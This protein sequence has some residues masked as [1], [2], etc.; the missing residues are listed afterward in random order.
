M[1]VNVKLY[2][3]YLLISLIYATAYHRKND[4]GVRNLHGDRYVVVNGLIAHDIVEDRLRNVEEYN[5]L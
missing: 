2:D 3:L 4:R 5:L 1:R